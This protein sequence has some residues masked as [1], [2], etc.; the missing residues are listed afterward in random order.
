MTETKLNRNQIKEIE[1][2]A[3]HFRATAL[4]FIDSVATEEFL[5]A[6]EQFVSQQINLATDVKTK[7]DEMLKHIKAYMKQHNL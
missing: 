6:D 5:I 3:L 4:N 2:C 7:A 1:N